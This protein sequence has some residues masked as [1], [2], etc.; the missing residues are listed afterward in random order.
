MAQAGAWDRIDEIASIRP[1]HVL[2][3]KVLYMYFPE[4]MIPITSG[5]HL[6]SFLEVM[7]HPKDETRNWG[8]VRLNRALL[9]ALR[10]VPT[11]R[12]WKPKEFEPLLYLGLRF[13]QR[14]IKIGIEEV[15]PSWDECR[16]KGYLRFDGDEIGDPGRFD[17]QEAYKAQ[18][19]ELYAQ[20]YGHNALFI[21]RKAS[22]LWTLVNLEPED[23]VIATQGAS[24]VLA[25]GRV[26]EPGYEWKPQRPELRHVVHVH[27]DTSYAQEIQL[28][29]ERASFGVAEVRPHLYQRILKRKGQTQPE[30][31][32]P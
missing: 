26:V 23:V 11:L 3:V 20:R 1:A 24:R 17:T 8:R 29:A 5:H 10:E 19:G 13:R 22:E 21:A 27:W 28:P 14:T 7:S 30:P 6:R 4:E 12:A 25:V 31:P 2:R 18:F 15:R 32:K 9:E 16:E